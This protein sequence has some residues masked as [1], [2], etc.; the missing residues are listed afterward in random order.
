MADGELMAV[1]SP[2]RFL[3]RRDLLYGKLVQQ[4]LRIV[5]GLCL[6][7]VLVVSHDDSAVEFAVFGQFL[8][9]V[10]NVVLGSVVF[11]RAVKRVA[12]AL[13]AGERPKVLV[14]WKTGQADHVPSLVQVLRVPPA[15]ALLAG[16]I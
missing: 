9:F 5:Y 12:D 7:L 13:D 15:V 3:G 1:V 8:A 4:C 10:S 6:S 14:D 2:Q 11:L 16:L